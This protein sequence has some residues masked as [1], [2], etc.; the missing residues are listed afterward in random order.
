[1][2][3]IGILQGKSAFISGATGGIGKAVAIAL[4][5]SGC[6]LFLTA[7][8]KNVLEKLA[9]ELSVHNVN[10]SYAAGNL[11][12]KDDVYFVIDKAKKSLGSREDTR[13]VV[14][15]PF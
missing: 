4:A 8:D 2:F 5:K 6:N 1:M 15:K 3:D 9:T 10:I 11:S 13:K 14:Q 12:N 7:T